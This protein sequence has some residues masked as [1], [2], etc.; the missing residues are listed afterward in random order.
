M[1]RNACS[2]LAR[3]SSRVRSSSCCRLSA[4][5]ESGSRAGMP[6]SSS[7]SAAAAAR[8]AAPAATAADCRKQFAAQ[9]A[10]VASSSPDEL[11]ALMKSDLS[12]WG[13]VI[14]DNNIQGE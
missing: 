1:T 3:V 9:G 8:R 2:R 12:Q 4:A 13:K 11:L 10:D 5:D 6:A 7:A 14:R